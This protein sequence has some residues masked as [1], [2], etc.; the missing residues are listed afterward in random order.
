M[1]RTFDLSLKGAYAALDPEFN[2]MSIV[3]I[4]EFA[5]EIT[6]TELME[7]SLTARSSTEKA[8]HATWEE[9]KSDLKVDQLSY[10]AVVF[11]RHTYTNTHP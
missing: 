7:A 6:H 8:F 5:G 1:T 9:F 11:S 4:R 10:A 3:P 2:E